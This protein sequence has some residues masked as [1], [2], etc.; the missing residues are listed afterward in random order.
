MG[1][2]SRRAFCAS[3]SGVLLV[4]EVAGAGRLGCCYI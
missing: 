3:V 2:D 1:S 4:I